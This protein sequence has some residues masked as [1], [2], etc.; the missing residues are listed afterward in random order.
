M[1]I[2]KSLASLADTLDK[3][4]LVKEADYLDHVLTKIAADPAVDINAKK[5]A[6]IKQLASDI[7]AKAPE[8]PARYEDKKIPHYRAR[9]GKDNNFIAKDEPVL[10]VGFSSTSAE[11][12]REDRL[13]LVEAMM[14][15]RESLISQAGF[16]Y[17]VT[18]QQVD[19]SKLADYWVG[20]QDLE[21]PK[22]SPDMMWLYVIDFEAKGGEPGLL[23]KMTESVKGLF[24]GE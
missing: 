21:P 19:T 5:E 7:N 15:S 24:G 20:I 2:L 18:Y 4:G 3:K 17:S 14:K 12:T 9:M 11:K 13:S 23:D 8:S 16:T 1:N 10:L 22:D 6:L